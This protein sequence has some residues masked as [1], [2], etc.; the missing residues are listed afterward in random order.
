[1]ESLEKLNQLLPTFDSELKSA[2]EGIVRYLPVTH[3][4]V[5]AQAL[6]ELW[7]ELELDGEP[8]IFTSPSH[9]RMQSEHHS[10][11]LDQLVAQGKQRKK[12][13]FGQLA[14]WKQLDPPA[15]AHGISVTGEVDYLLKA[16]L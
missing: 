7:R 11:L 4:E 1:M 9:S 16:D 2:N 13:R 6:K 8:L 14:S 12:P 5:V 10:M 15:Y 3:S